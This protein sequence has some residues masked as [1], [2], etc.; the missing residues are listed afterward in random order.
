MIRRAEAFIGL[1]KYDD[2]INALRYDRPPDDPRVHA[3][4]AE[5]YFNRGDT[6]GD[7]FS[8]H[9][10]VEKA[11]AAGLTDPKLHAIRALC[12]FRKERY[13]EAVEAFQRLRG[14]AVAAGHAVYARPVPA[15]PRP[16]GRRA[17]PG[18]IAR[19]RRNRSKARVPAGPRG[20]AG[21]PE[22]AQPRRRKRAWTKAPQG[23]G[24]PR[25]QRPLDVPTPYRHSAVST[26]RGAGRPAASDFLLA[27]EEHSLPAGLPRRHRHPGVPQR[28]LPR[29]LRR[30]LSHQ[31][32]RQR[33]SGRAG[34]GVLAS[35][36]GRLPPW[37]G[38]PGRAGGHLLQQ[39]V[40]RRLQD[41]GLRADAAV[42]PGLRQEGGGD[43]RGR[44]RP[45]RRAQSRADGPCGDGL[46][47][48]HAARAA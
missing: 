38:Q 44:V 35:V 32:A 16:T 20:R 48:A 24:G 25:D 45:G 37:L 47:E 42:V 7:L 39:A 21:R 10:F 17:C 18:S 4:L 27:G 14:R 12:A 31:P 36:R 9:F 43:R 41:A 13:A 3:L 5:A 8:A 26:L 29:R 30:G 2:A 15:P 6:R 28:H 23:L 1:R 40:G 19:S 22:P 11:L 46:R 33:L 34:P